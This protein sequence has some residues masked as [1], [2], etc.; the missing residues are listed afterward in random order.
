MISYKGTESHIIVPEGIEVIG[1]NA[2]F[3]NALLKGVALPNSLKTIDDNAFFACKNLESIII[4][5]KVTHIGSF[6]FADCINLKIINIPCTA[7]HIGKYAFSC[8]FGTA[9][10]KAGQEQ[11]KVYIK[12]PKSLKSLGEGSFLGSDGIIV[13]DTLCQLTEDRHNVFSQTDDLIKNSKFGHALY[14]PEK[15]SGHWVDSCRFKP[16]LIMVKSSQTEEVLCAIWMASKDE[17][18]KYLDTIINLW[19][20]GGFF[21][22]E[23]YDALF[24]T[25]ISPVDKIQ[26]AFYRLQYPYALKENYKIEYENFLKKHVIEAVETID[27]EHKLNLLQ[28]LVEKAMLTE[29]NI[30]RVFESLNNNG[31][32]KCVSWIMN[33]KNKHH[34]NRDSHLML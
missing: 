22:F 33:Y 14:D 15:A 3:K 6:A 18:R 34:F 8:V 2:F 24:D 17:R 21:D 16:H 25:M 19:E 9:G 27:L 12:L 5:D 1:K 20:A 31:Y 28:L 23:E 29:E 32:T 26:V 11:S 4:K 10:I 30:D 7:T 13:Y